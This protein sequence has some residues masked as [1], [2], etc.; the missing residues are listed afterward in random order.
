MDVCVCLDGCLGGCFVVF[1][2]VDVWGD[3][4]DVW[5]YVGGVI[6]A[7]FQQICATK[8]I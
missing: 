3:G 4:M 8:L 7:K 5:M 2:W 6:C 1:V